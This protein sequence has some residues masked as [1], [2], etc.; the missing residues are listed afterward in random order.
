VAKA[1]VEVQ[2]TKDGPSILI[3]STVSE[4]TPG[5]VDAASDTGLVV[6]AQKTLTD[7]LSNVA[8]LGD[9]IVSRLNDAV[10]RPK[11]V[12]VEFGIKFGAK[13]NVIVA[14]GSAE[15]NCKITMLWEL[16]PKT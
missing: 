3:E 7:A 15:A 5:F 11:S 9:A 1:L 2:I 12:E 4:G 6:R 10:H 13:G 8:P 16:P 14:G